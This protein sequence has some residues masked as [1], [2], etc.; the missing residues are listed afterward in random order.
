MYHRSQKPQDRSHARDKPGQCVV[1]VSP[2]LIL[3]GAI[4]YIFRNIQPNELGRWFPR[5]GRVVQII[6]SILAILIITLTLLSIF[7]VL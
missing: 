4:P 3:L 5:S 6:F 2:V 7:K 1:R